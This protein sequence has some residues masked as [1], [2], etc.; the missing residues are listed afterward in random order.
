MRAAGRAAGNEPRSRWKSHQIRLSFG[1]ENQPEK[2]VRPQKLLLPRLAQRLSNQPVGFT[3]CRT[4]QIRNRGRRR[5]KNHQRNPRA[6]GR[7]CGQI[8]AWGPERRNRYRPK[9]CRH[10][11]VGSGIRT[12]NAFRH[13]SRC[14]RQSLAQ[15]GHMAGHLRRQHGG[16]FFPRRCQRI[17]APERPSGI[18]HAPRD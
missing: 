12:R 3:D 5:C 18:R 15:L 2:R 17:R 16:R 7:R 1:C 11:A 14:L 9:P 4:R 10:A 6:H 8:R 13:R